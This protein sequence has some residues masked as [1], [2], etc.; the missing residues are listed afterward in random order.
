M[1]LLRVGPFKIVGT[2]FSFSGKILANKP[3]NIWNESRT[4]QADRRAVRFNFIKFSSSLS[5]EEQCARTH[6]GST[7]ALL[8][9]MTIF[10][11]EKFSNSGPEMIVGRRLDWV[12]SSKRIIFD[13]QK[14]IIKNFDKP[15]TETQ[16]TRKYSLLHTEN[17]TTRKC[18]EYVPPA[19]TPYFLAFYYHCANEI[20]RFT[21]RHPPKDKFHVKYFQERLALEIRAPPMRLAV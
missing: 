9:L 14:N 4:I 7:I 6:C 20:R 21:A 13:K 8:P 17:N 18:G 1:R 2:H 3:K 15:M 19:K 11:A 10:C 16:K 5:A 12:E